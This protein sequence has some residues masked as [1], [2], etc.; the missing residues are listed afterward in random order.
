MSSATN[1]TPPGLLMQQAGRLLFPL[2]IPLCG[3]FFWLGT[4][5]HTQ[6]VHSEIIRENAAAIRDL[7]RVV[8]RQQSRLDAIERRLMLQPIP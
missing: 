1:G 3:A 8:E 2:V 7:I 5:A 4:V 6:E